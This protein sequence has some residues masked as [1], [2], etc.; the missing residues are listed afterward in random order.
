[1]DRNHLKFKSKRGVENMLGYYPGC[2]VRA[3]KD[4]GF[5]RESMAILNFFGV[6]AHELS[7]WECCGAVYPLT[8]DEYVPLLSS[9]RALQKT[10]E[11]NR[12]GLL[13]LCSACYH[14]LKRVNYRMKND[15]EAKKRVGSYLQ[16]EYE[17]DT[18]VYH[19][20]EALRD[21][22][23]LDKLREKTV[24]PLSEEKIACYYGCLFLRPKEEMGL[25]DPEN[26]QLMEE[27]VKALGAEPV[28]FPYSTDCC[29]SYHAYQK[30]GISQNISERIVKSAKKVGA[31]QIVTACPLCKH[32]LEDCQK[33]WDERDKLPIN[34]IT[35]PIVQA[36]G[37]LEELEKEEFQNQIAN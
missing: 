13:T 33:K 27:I 22:I 30:E 6:Y 37:G 17:G 15:K 36:L 18:K 10:K 19:L 32:N 8:E 21:F 9:V 23:G 4:D 34:Y 31:T 16:F 3:Q 2:T 5:E 25:L 26:P 1:M 12:Q 20:I 28:K 7:Q 35:V 29:G 14:V 11:E 24:S